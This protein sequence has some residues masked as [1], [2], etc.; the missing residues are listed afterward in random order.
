[1]P[2]SSIL[3][4]Q[5]YMGLQH[6]RNAARIPVTFGLGGVAVEM[7]LPPSTVWIGE[8]GQFGSNHVLHPGMMTAWPQICFKKKMYITHHTFCFKARHVE[9]YWGKPTVI[10]KP[11]HCPPNKLCSVTPNLSTNKNAYNSKESGMNIAKLLANQ[12]KVLLA[13]NPVLEFKGIM[14]SKP[15]SFAG[16]GH[17]HLCASILHVNITG[18]YEEFHIYDLDGDHF[19]SLQHFTFPLAL[20]SKTLDAA[21]SLTDVFKSS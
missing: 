12:T 4:I 13:L 5:F 20:S 19:Y 1:M 11:V 15:I 2:L 9:F 7:K 21:I 14:K 16:P 8:Q 10:S 17:K 18:E 3:S 6:S